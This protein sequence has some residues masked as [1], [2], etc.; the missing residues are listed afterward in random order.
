MLN[1]KVEC[2]LN[3]TVMANTE[4][5]NR[6]LNA[7][8]EIIE[9]VPSYILQEEQEPGKLKKRKKVS[10]VQLKDKLDSKMRKL[11]TTQANVVYLM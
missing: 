4:E 1:I 2:E 11:E 9:L 7:Y 6:Y 3:T 8:Q 5:L 10:L